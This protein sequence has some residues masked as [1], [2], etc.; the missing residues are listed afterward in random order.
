MSWEDHTPDPSAARY[1]LRSGQARQS[2]R[3]WGHRRLRREVGLRRPG[4]DSDEPCHPLPIDLEKHRLLGFLRALQH[5]DRLLRSLDLLLADLLQDVAR[6]QALVIGRAARLDGGDQRAVDLLLEAE[7]LAGLR[8][9]RRQG[10][11]ERA[12]LRSLGRLVLRTVLVVGF[13]LLVADGR[14]AELGVDR[15]R[16]AVTDQAD[17]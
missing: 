8:R 6:A 5:V 10:E 16:L 13:R 3:W 17:L 4:R 11:A 9:D 12:G 1:T 7:L 14:V 15:H 2:R